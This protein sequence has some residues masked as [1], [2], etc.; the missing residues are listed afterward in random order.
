MTDEEK[1]K[2]KKTDTIR[3]TFIFSEEDWKA[4]GFDEKPEPLELKR[5][6]YDLIHTVH[7]PELPEIMSTTMVARI[8]NLNQQTVK[9][10]AQ[11]GKLPAVK[12]GNRWKFRKE[13]ILDYLDNH[14]GQKEQAEKIRAREE[15]Q[16]ELRD[17]LRKIQ[18]MRHKRKKKA[19]S[20]DTPAPI[21]R[22]K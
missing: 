1:K 17:E 20:E 8:L 9:R 12:T 19:E 21:K 3:M 18:A 16:G 2:E 22:K 11:E 15:E 14:N 13:D 5:T 4:V 6:I 10:Y 7:K